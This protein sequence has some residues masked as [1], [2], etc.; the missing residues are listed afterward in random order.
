V[1]DAFGDTT[2]VHCSDTY[3]A[4]A[5]GELH[6]EPVRD[7]AQEGRLVARLQETEP[8]TLDRGALANDDASGDVVGGHDEIA[9]ER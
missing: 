3:P 4:G 1:D 5:V 9:G 6:A 7:G 2:R 8:G